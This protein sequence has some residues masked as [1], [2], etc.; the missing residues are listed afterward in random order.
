MTE[1]EAIRARHSVR[2]YLNKPLKPDELAAL[3][4]EMAACN[5][6]SGLH[7]QLIVNEPKAFQGS[8]ARYGKFSGVNNYFALIGK[9]GPEL[10]EKCGYWGERLVLFA[11]MMELNT[12]WV[13][14]TFNKVKFAYTLDEGEKLAAVIAL[15]R[16]A[17][18]GVPH[19][20]RAMEEVAAVIALGRGDTQGVSHN[21]RAIEEVTGVAGSMPDWFKA[22]M[23]AVLLA[24]TAMNQQKFTFTLRSDGKVLAQPGRALYAKMDLGIAKY[25]F[26]IGAGK[27][28]FQ[29][30]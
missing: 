20:S 24:P 16:G 21:S 13:A 3:R 28:N 15:G 18:Q 17:T 25:H 9:A 5:Q 8:M 30:A 12:C 6:E 7:I 2:Q 1:L 4:A 26:E 29:W 14:L 19:N 23:E 22:G 10:Q 11:Q 27:E